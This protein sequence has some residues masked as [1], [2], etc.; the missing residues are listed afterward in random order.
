[1]S[2]VA[3]G[4]AAEAVREAAAMRRLLAGQVTAGDTRVVACR[5]VRSRT[6]PG[7]RRLVQF[8]V[9]LERGDGRRRE[10]RVT[11]QWHA[12]PERAAHHRRKALRLGARLDAT[13]TEPLPPV[14][15]DESTGVLGTTF[16]CDLRLTALPLVV[17][18]SAPAV[19]GPMLADAGLSAGDVR[20]VT[21]DTV[22][23]RE[24]LNAV[25]RYTLHHGDG[26]FDRRYYVKVYADDGGAALAVRLS[27]VARATARL[28]G[29]ARVDRALAYL[30]SIRAL[31]LAEAP[32]TPLDAWPI[33]P[34]DAH[35]RR[36]ARVARA[37][38]AFATCH[39][40]AVPARDVAARLDQTARAAAAVSAGLP[41]LAGTIAAVVR[42]AAGRLA[43]GPPGLTHG[44]VKLEH[45]LVADDAVRLIDLDSSH[46]G[47]ARWDLAL[48]EARVW[49]AA[50][51]GG[52]AGAGEWAQR[53]LAAAYFGAHD[54]WR[55]PGLGAL[56]ALACLDVAAG[57]L[58]RHEDDAHGRAR[59]LL[60]HAAQSLVA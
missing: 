31:V 36:L 34:S 19:V 56:R 8:A 60:A 55:R 51:R 43:D 48:L 9:T 26:R 28:P 16:P 54:G 42:A 24:Q 32:G 6:R 21:V 3:P 49:A 13:W 39:A 1:M 17:G 30:P 53:T 33:R 14:F 38:A 11:T 18:G 29:A 40:E 57:V 44:D 47:D 35:A 45:V 7:A 10:A 25:C 23:Y 50:D 52:D 4:P 15:I 59:R 20:G 5:V 12:D 37:L 2:A 22:R 41:D 58:K 27:A 46:L